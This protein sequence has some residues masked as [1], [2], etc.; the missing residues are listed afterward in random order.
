MLIRLR[1]TSNHHNRILL[2]FKIQDKADTLKSSSWIKLSA[3]NGLE[4]PT[5]GLLTIDIQI[6]GKVFRDAHVL[7]VQDPIDVDMKRTKEKTPGIIGCNILQKMYQDYQQQ[8]AEEQ[9]YSSDVKRGLKQYEA[10]VGFCQKIEAELEDKETDTLGMVKLPKSGLRIPADSEIIATGTTRHLPVGYNVLV[11]TTETSLPQGIVVNSSLSRVKNG[12]VKI[13]I[14][15]YNNKDITL[16]RSTRIAQIS[17]CDLIKPDVKV[18]LNSEG[19]EAT[20]DFDTPQKSD[21]DPV[22]EIPIG[23]ESM[24][25]KDRATIQNLF[26]KYTDVFSKSE[27]DLGFTD[28]VEHRI[29]TEDNIPIKQ[30]DRRV[31]PNQI[32]EVKK[33][34]DEWLKIGVIQES[35]SPYASQMVLVKKK[36]GSIR[37]CI[38]FRSLNNKTIK[39]AFPIPKIEECIDSLKG[40]KYFCSLDL[41]Q[42]YLQVKLSEEDQHKTAFRALGSL[43]EWTRLPFGLCNSPATFSR[44]MGKCFQG[45]Y[46]KGLIIYLDDMLIYGSSIKEVTD[47]LET[48]FTILRQNGLK[49]KPSKCNFSKK[50][51]HF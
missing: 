13:H 8:T 24:S 41:T 51:S 48:V 23:D 38:D 16:P 22:K 42:G 40:A 34:L 26:Q 36:N 39:D 46:K 25:K 29:I 43:Y 32:P 49:L 37:V 28:V 45:L 3:S 27:Y 19:N 4:I 44:L 35:C 33:I 1:I 9:M 30:P 10:R 12:K 7:V 50:K 2:Q 47:R 18:Q 14:T 31:P 6:Q 17:A 15:N 20:V 11:E 21:E 5:K